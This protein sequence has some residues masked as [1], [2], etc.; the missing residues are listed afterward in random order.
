MSQVLAN[1]SSFPR[2]PGAQR[3]EFPTLLE[4]LK[5]GLAAAN[6]PNP[7]GFTGACYTAAEWAVLHPGAPYGPPADPGDPPLLAAGQVPWSF[8][9]KRY[10]D[11]ITHESACKTALLS[12]LD[13][14]T[15]AVVKERD[16]TL[17]TT[18]LATII[19]RL[20]DAYQVA[21]PADISTNSDKLKRP[22]SPPMPLA[23]HLLAHRA[24]HAYAD[25]QGFPI[26]E[27]TKVDMLRQSLQPCNIFNETL[28]LF[29]VM[30]TTVVT[31]TFEALA[32]MLLTAEANLAS[33]T[34]VVA[35]GYAQA[36]TAVQLS[37]L[38]ELVRSLQAEVRGANATK[39]AG[40][41]PVARASPAAFAP[42]NVHYCWTHGSKS[43]HPSFACMKP[44]HGHQTKA[45]AKA[46]LGGKA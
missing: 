18:P 4:D 24:A 41:G 10:S 27:P 7:L 12:K 33:Q 14:T 42:G 25:A 23:D 40:G 30:F 6:P 22:Y 46:T 17:S 1:I 2:C 39:M 16:G 35:A 21:T 45:T 37:N 11:F 5:T 43:A 31:Q 8:L 29:V 44:A 13:A 36:V 26:L 15:L 28:K 9:Y 38:E 3:L 32:T 20:R 34:T 19:Q